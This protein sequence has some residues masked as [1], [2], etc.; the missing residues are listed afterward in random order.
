M[1]ELGLE[2]GAAEDSKDTSEK[3]IL[4]SLVFMTFFL[5]QR[6]MVNLGIN[7]LKIKVRVFFF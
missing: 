6:N 5:M 2:P 3:G 1:R 7:S 4:C